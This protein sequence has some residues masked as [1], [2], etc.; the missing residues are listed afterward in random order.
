VSEALPNGQAD[1][2]APPT[3]MAAVQAGV[4]REFH[5]L[6]TD[7]EDLLKSTT[8]LTGDDLARAKAKLSARAT[9]ARESIEKMGVVIADRARNTATATDGYVH[10]RPWQAIGI[11]AALGLVAGFMLARRR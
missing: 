7:I 10:E 11:G 3:V 1:P 8:S 6:F 9:A 4:S 2:S 5:S